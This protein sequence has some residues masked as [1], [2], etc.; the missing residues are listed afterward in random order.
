MITPIGFLILLAAVF[1][2]TWLVI[3][4]LFFAAG[5]IVSGINTTFTDAMIVALVGAIC[6]TVLTAIF[7]YLE[8]SLV[9]FFTD[10]G[11]AWFVPYLGFTIS[12]L[13]TLCVY[14]PL[15]MK[16]FDTGFWGAVAVGLLVII[17]QIILAATIFFIILILAI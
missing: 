10:L 1:L 3:S 6:Y 16:F 8:P 15:I 7:Q 17:F 14:I 9:L 4:L 12:S 13:I 5:R 11:L 2:V